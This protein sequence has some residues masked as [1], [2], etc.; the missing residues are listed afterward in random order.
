LGASQALLETMGLGLQ[1]GDRHDIRRYVAT[2]R[3]QLDEATFEAAWEEGG[4][5]SFE[6]AFSYA[7]EVGQFALDS[8]R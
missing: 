6:Q 3:E 2:V 4:A 8:S 5:M 7:L 1:P